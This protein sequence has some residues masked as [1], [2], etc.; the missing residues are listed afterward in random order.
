M[1]LDQFLKKYQGYAAMVYKIDKP[2]KLI[3]YDSPIEVYYCYEPHE[4]N[5]WF[6]L[7]YNKK[8]IT[9]TISFPCHVKYE[10]RS[11]IAENMTKEFLRYCDFRDLDRELLGKCACDEYNYSSCNECE[12]L[13]TECLG[14][15]YSM[16]SHVNWW[17]D[18]ETTWNKVYGSESENY[19]NHILMKAK[20][21]IL[22]AM[23]SFDGDKKYMNELIKY[24]KHKQ[25]CFS[26]RNPLWTLKNLYKKYKNK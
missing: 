7:F 19:K 3:E 22:T 5:C 24:M 4:D 10:H 12:K 17:Q 13:N 20:T 14:P 15:T 11:L 16:I 2:H 25:K 18:T 9:N 8:L 1:T 23:N 6:Y 26:G 21:A